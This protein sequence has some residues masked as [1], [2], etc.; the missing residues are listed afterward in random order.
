MK[1]LRYI[2]GVCGIPIAGAAMLFARV[3]AQDLR[4]VHFSGVINDYSSSTSP[5]GPYEIRGDWSPDV[6][7]GTAN[8]LADL[9]ME[10]SITGL[11]APPRWIRRIRPPVARTRTISA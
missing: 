1:Q 9:N 10:R 4:P 7:G 3:Q 5:G 6:A 8:F 11:P 2:T